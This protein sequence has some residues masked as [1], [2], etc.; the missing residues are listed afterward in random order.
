MAL[1]DAS[2]IK[3][4]SNNSLAAL[5]VFDVLLLVVIIYS[6]LTGASSNMAGGL[7]DGL[8]ALVIFVLGPLG[9]VLCSAKAWFVRR[10]KKSLLF[11]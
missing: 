8:L 10:D 3:S 11:C 2:S 6:V 1:F 4:I 7:G 9:A 5:T